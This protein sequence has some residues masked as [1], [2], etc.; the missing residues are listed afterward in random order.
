M[1]RRIA[2]ITD[3]HY[4]WKT[5]AETV[6]VQKW[7]AADARERGCCATLL[8]GDLLDGRSVPAD[9][10]AAAEG[11]MELAESGP[12]VGVVGNH[13][14]EA[15]C[16]IFNQL[17][18]R[19][20]ITIY[21]RPT[22]H[23]LRDLGIAV[24]CLPWP[25]LGSLLAGL[26]NPSH[27]VTQAAAREAMQSILLGLGQGLD[28]HP[29]LARIG[30]AHVSISGAKTDQDQPIRGTEFVLSTGELAAMRASLY[31]F[32]HI[33]AQNVLRIGEAEGLYGGA[34]EHRNFG[35]GGPKGYVVF[36][37]DGT[38]IVGWRRIPTPVAPMILASGAFDGRSLTHSHQ[39]R[40]VAGAV[41]RLQ[42]K[43]GVD[44]RAGGKAA[45]DDAKREM[46][47]RGALSVTPEE[48]L[49]A[50]TRARNPEVAAAVDHRKKLQLHWASKKFEPGDRRESLLLKADFLHE[51]THEV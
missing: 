29:D 35:E 10:N 24:A 37:T 7:I 47:A 44:M 51:A 1:I 40:D 4:H 45:A 39:G 50:E 27:E 31:L 43:V 23:P 2:F 18:G 13:E 32:G 20:P 12:V 8:G 9:R 28:A 49:E 17:R 3:Q 38:R 25:H 46:M 33:H 14:V 15:D 22:V 21:D 36:E 48:V 11:L 6:R 16:D 5:L 34:P 41:V 19:H 42:Y 26:E 30:L